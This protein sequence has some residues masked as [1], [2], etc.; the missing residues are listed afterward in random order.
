MGDQIDA[1]LV[2]TPNHTHQYIIKYCILKGKHVY[3]EKPLAH[4]IRE[5]RDLMKME[6]KTGLACPMGNQG[7]SGSGIKQ[8]NDWI[9]R[10]FLDEVNEVHAWTVVGWNNAKQD[11]IK[12]N[13]LR[14]L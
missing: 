4:N 12:N 9:E 8:L 1:V 14:M 11:V 6:K 13:V 10:G 7:H 2:S 5:V 3:L